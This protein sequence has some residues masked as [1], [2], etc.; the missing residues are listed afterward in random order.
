MT[1]IVLDKEKS[2]A[3]VQQWRRNYSVKL[4]DMSSH[5]NSKAGYVTINMRLSD[6]EGSE[7]SITKTFPKQD[8][9]SFLGNDHNASCYIFKIGTS[10]EIEVQ[11]NRYLIHH[12]FHD[13]YFSNFHKVKFFKDSTPQID[14]VD[15]IIAT[16]VIAFVLL[17]FLLCCSVA[18]NIVQFLAK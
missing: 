2:N 6:F 3:I 9:P 14:N 16:S 10:I 7:M 1:H 13:F 18:M 5:Y 15:D 17:I 12:L 4:V 8:N 11:P